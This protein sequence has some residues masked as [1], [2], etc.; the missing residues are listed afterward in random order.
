[1]SVS[2]PPATTTQPSRTIRYVGPFAAFLLLLVVAGKVPL[3]PWVEAPLRVA[4][5]AVICIVLWPREISIAPK[6]VLSSVMVGLAVFAIWIAPE[7]LVHGYRSLPLF[8]NAIVGQ[9]HSSLPPQSLT[10]PWVLGWRTA[11]AALIVPP[12]EEL[13]WRGW[14]M[15][16]LIDRDFGRIPVGTYAAGAFWTTAILFASEHGPYWDVGLIAGVIYNL[17]A[18]RTK[19]VA[20]C[21]LA[22]AVTNL[23][24][25]LYVI[26]A[27]QWQYWQ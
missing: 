8:S 7:L 23:A 13:F 17:W 21:M 5:L 1:M 3:S 10:S 14:L 4:V 24:L 11:R 16:W 19:S 18:I 26:G 6:R 25:S 12:I 27:A 22:H 20:D 15:R 9:I 2:A